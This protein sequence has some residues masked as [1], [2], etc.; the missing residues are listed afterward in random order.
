MAK[1]IAIRKYVVAIMQIARDLQK[2]F[3]HMPGKQAKIVSDSQ[4]AHALRQIERN[5]YPA[6]DRVMLLLS[7]KAGL[8]ACE[9][10]RLTWPPPERQMLLKANGR[11]DNVI[12]LP[13]HAARKG[14]GRSIPLHPELKTALTGLLKQDQGEGPVIRPERG[15][16]LSAR[17]VVNWF[18]QLYREMGLEGCSSHSGRRTFITKAARCIARSGGSLRD[19]Q[20]LAGHKSIAVTQRYIDADSAAQRRLVRML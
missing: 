5:R 8:R 14:A 17:S 16:A 11:L 9:I 4:L 20:I 7:L 13:D 19:V 6:R 1:F 3:R 10:A 2:E 15:E 12:T 18:R